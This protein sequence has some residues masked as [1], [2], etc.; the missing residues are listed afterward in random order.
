MDDGYY[1]AVGDT[2]YDRIA[3]AFYHAFIG[4]AYLVRKFQ[5]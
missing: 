5:R 2:E 3:T 1:L 4:D